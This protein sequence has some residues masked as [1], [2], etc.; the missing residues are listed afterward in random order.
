MASRMKKENIIFIPSVLHQQ[1]C[2]QPSVS[3]VI[4]GFLQIPSGIARE[5]S[6]LQQIA[7]RSLWGRT[8]VGI[9]VAINGQDRR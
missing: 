1:M 7:A 6:R 8:Y 9:S 4:Y 5:R 2:Q 3:P